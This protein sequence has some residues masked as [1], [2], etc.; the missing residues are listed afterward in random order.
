MLVDGGCIG[1]WRRQFKCLVGEDQ[2]AR[3]R[4]QEPTRDRAPQSAAT[5]TRSEEEATGS[6]TELMGEHVVD[7]V[8]LEESTSASSGTQGIPDEWL[9]LVHGTWKNTS[10]ENIEEY[11]KHLGNRIEGTWA[12]AFEAA[13]RRSLNQTEGVVRSLSDPSQL[14][15]RY[16]STI[17]Q[18][19][20]SPICWSNGP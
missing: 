12:R 5:A 10:T 8:P 19:Y 2:D 20:S 11:L 9:E 17:L 13:L 6:A 14:S 7:S 18:V 1:G 16:G 3:S 15:C 4:R